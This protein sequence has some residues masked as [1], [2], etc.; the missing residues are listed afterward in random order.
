MT[1]QFRRGSPAFPFTECAHTPPLPPFASRLRLSCVLPT[2]SGH[3][4]RGWG[5]TGSGRGPRWGLP[6][7]QHRGRGAGEG[8]Q[9]GG[10]LRGGWGTPRLVLE[11]NPR[12]HLMRGVE[13]VVEGG[14]KEGTQVGTGQS[15][16]C[17]PVE[18]FLEEPWT[19]AAPG[20][21]GSPSGSSEEVGA[22]PLWAQGPGGGW[23]GEWGTCE[24]P[25]LPG[26]GAGS[27]AVLGPAAWWASRRWLLLWPKRRWR[28]Q[29]GGVLEA[30]VPQGAGKGDAEGA[31]VGLRQ[32]GLA[33]LQEGERPAGSG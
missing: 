14:G 4:R 1:P 13:Q 26:T 11:N 27:Q 21:G 10:S 20:T 23:E 29:G 24:T 28:P 17:L 15:Q 30:G 9:A 19:G 16:L 7:D 32:L 6:A 12:R 5:V 3:G 33:V 2:C 8:P 22:G 18:T 31:G 25:G